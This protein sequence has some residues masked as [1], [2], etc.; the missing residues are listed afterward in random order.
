MSYNNMFKSDDAYIYGH[1]SASKSQHRPVQ[2]PHKHQQQQQ[3]QSAIPSYSRPAPPPDPYRSKYNVS[4]L[5]TSKFEQPW[6]FSSKVRPSTSHQQPSR[7]KSGDSAFF[8]AGAREQPEHYTPSVDVKRHAAVHGKKSERQGVKG[9][10]GMGEGW[11]DE[12]R[13]G[14]VRKSEMGGGVGSGND[15]DGGKKK[16]KRGFW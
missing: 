2:Q 8:Y 15:V 14:M 11:S 3:Q 13:L 6:E 16:K 9:G 5:G 1:S 4:P 7:S 12:A 10:Y